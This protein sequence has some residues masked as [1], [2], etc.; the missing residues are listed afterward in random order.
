M[1]YENGQSLRNGSKKMQKRL[2]EYSK[3]FNHND[4]MYIV[5]GLINKRR[6]SGSSWACHGLAHRTFPITRIVLTSEF[7]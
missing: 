4:S 3:N 6:N 5:G 2:K 1:M 7:G